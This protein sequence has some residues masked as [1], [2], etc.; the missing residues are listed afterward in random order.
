M[1]NPALSISELPDA[2][3]VV[4]CHGVMT[5]VPTTS[6]RNDGGVKEA[7]AL[8]PLSY[9]PDGASSRFRGR[10]GMETAWHNPSTYG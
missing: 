4:I 2:R 7:S 8:Y 9:S 10:Y 6:K 1:E 3:A 5:F